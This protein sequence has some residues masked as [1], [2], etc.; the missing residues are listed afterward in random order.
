MPDT[1]AYRKRA[2]ELRELAEKYKNI[3]E[4]SDRYLELAKAWDALAGNAERH[5]RDGSGGR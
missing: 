2:D 4:I 3:P 1:D 5:W